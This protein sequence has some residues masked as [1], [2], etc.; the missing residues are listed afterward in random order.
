[1]I[2]V[3]CIDWPTNMSIG[4]V[5]GNQWPMSGWDVTGDVSIGY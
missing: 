2:M 3:G 4:D 1:M 5:E